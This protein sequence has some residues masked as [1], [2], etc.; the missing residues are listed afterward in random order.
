MD[1][2]M[3]VVV[4]VL[5]ETEGVGPR[6]FGTAMG[7]ILTISQVG[8]VISPPLGNSLAS[9]NSGLPFIFWAA[10]SAAALFTI[11]PIKERSHF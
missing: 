9:L 5:L 10:L 8:S 4:T 3:A 2:F 7:I 6:E 1:G 11:A